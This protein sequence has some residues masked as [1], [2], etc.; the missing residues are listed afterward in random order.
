MVNIPG[1]ENAQPRCLAAVDRSLAEED[2]SQ[3][4]PIFRCLLGS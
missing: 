1:L 2:M 3:I 4:A